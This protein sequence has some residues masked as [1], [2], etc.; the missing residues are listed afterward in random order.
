M[1]GVKVRGVCDASLTQASRSLLQMTMQR[2]QL[3]L[4]GF[5]VPQLPTQVSKFAKQ[6]FSAISFFVRASAGLAAKATSSAVIGAPTNHRH[7]LPG[8]CGLE[9][10]E[11]KRV[12][13]RGD[14]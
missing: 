12:M 9:N 4:P 3:K 10:A 7:R 11:A 8:I 5:S 14:T 6:L 1:P 13:S 2:S